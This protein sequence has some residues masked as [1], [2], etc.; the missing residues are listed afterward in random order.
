MSFNPKFGPGQSSVTHRQGLNSTT[1]IKDTP[2]VQRT[3]K[4]AE[5][6]PKKVEEKP[7]AEE[8]KPV[9]TPKKT[10]RKRTTRKKTTK[11]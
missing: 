6:K 7:K 3:P 9:E 11:K 10:T 4:P 1:Y 2:T 5:E 8:V